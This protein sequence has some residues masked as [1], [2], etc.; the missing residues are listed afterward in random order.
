MCSL[1]DSK[2]QNHCS[3]EEG[4]KPL[5]WGITESRYVSSPS[6]N[7]ISMVAASDLNPAYFVVP[8]AFPH[9]LPLP[10]VVTVDAVNAPRSWGGTCKK[11]WTGW[12]KLLPHRFLSFLALRAFAPE[13]KSLPLTDKPKLRAYI[14]VNP[15]ARLFCRLFGQFA[16]LSV[17]LSHS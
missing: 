11:E 1:F 6:H 2:G 3:R 8:T 5:S 10:P 7:S 16:S 13:G 17:M 9:I 4:M 15:F 14:C 12:L